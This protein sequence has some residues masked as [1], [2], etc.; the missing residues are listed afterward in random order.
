M[1]IQVGKDIIEVKTPSFSGK[2]VGAVIV[3]AV[4]N[5]G[6]EKTRFPAAFEEVIAVT[7]TDA[8][9]R[10]YTQANRGSF[11]GVA[12]PGV[13]SVTTG[14]GNSIQSL[15]GTSMAAAYVSGVAALLLE[16]DPT[17]KP[18]EVRALIEASTIDLGAPGR[19]NEYGS[20]RVDA[21][22]A[23]SRG[24]QSSQVPERPAG[25]P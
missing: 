17:L 16:R 19:D 7:A 8:R 14:P 13:D 25:R 15:S 1:R 5:D 10:L 22:R 3:A 18:A 2:A 12:A 24:R 23:V 21:F 11:V 20:G 4:G 6:Q 9:D